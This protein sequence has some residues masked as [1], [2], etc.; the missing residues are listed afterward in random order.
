MSEER[1]TGKGYHWRSGTDNGFAV[2][3]LDTRQLDEEGLGF[4]EAVFILTREALD[5]YDRKIEGDLL[6]ICHHVS[7]HISKNKKHIL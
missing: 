2:D 7:R 6:D 3:N 5:S 4:F 1:R